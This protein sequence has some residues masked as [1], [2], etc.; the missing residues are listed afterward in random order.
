MTD[1]LIKH[2]SGIEKSFVTD[3]VI[4]WFCYHLLKNNNK[5]YS[6]D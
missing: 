3:N 5:K 4:V 1:I 2:Q 6:I